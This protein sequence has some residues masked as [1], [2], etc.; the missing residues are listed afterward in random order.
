MQL[1]ALSNQRGKRIG[2]RGRSTNGQMPVM[3]FNLA[4]LVHPGHVEHLFKMHVHFVD[5]QPHIGAAS[6]NLGL[7]VFDAL[8]QQLG[9]RG[10]ANISQIKLKPR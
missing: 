9:Q 10:G 6:H 5:P 7:R 4:Q 8:G 1:G 3:A 2:Q